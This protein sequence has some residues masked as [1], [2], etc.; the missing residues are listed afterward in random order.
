MSLVDGEITRNSVHIRIK[1]QNGGACMTGV[2]QN[3]QGGIE[4]RA[5][6]GC[7]IP[8]A[9]RNTRSAGKVYDPIR[10]G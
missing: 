9:F 1:I 2:F 10:G 7:R 3:R 5:I 6:K 8:P 4:V